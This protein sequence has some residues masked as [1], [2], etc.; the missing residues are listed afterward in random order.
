MKLTRRLCLEN[1]GN[2]HRNKKA[3]SKRASGRGEIGLKVSLFKC[4]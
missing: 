4:Q 2:N 1:G 3:R